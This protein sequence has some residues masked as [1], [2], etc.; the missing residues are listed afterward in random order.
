[1]GGGLLNLVAYGNK[2]I[3][4]N[5]NPSKTFFKTTY[6]KYTNFGLQKFRLDFDGPKVL[7]ENTRSYYEF[8]VPLYGDL[9]MDTY[10]VITMPHIWSPLY[11]PDIDPPCSNSPTDALW[12][13]CLRDASNN[14][15][16]QAFTSRVI[17]EGHYAQ[18]YEF[19]W[20]ENLGSQL[21]QSIRYTIGGQIVQEFSGQYLYNMVQR[22]FSTAKKNLFNE[23][24]GHTDQMN[25]PANFSTNSGNYPNYLGQALSCGPSI[26]GRQLYIPLNI[27]S[28]LSSKLSIPLVCLQKNQIK[29]NIECRPIRELFVVRDINQYISRQWDVSA[30]APGGLTYNTDIS[31]S[32]PPY[33]STMNIVDPKYQMYLFLTQL[34]EGGIA[35]LYPSLQSSGVVFDPAK[36]STWDADPHLIATYGFI[37]QEE[38]RQFVENPPSYLVKQVREHYIERKKHTLD[39][40][41]FRTSGL[42]SSWM[43][44]FQRDD[45]FLRNEWSNY[46]NWPYNYIPYPC[47]NMHDL[48]NNLEALSYPKPCAPK[49]SEA[50]NE[51]GANCFPYAPYSKFSDPSSCIPC[52]TGQYH[53]DNISRIMKIWSL[54][55]D[56]NIREK[57]LAASVLDNVEKYVRT[58][59]NGKDGLYCYNF[60][61]NTDP[62]QYQPNGAMN[63]S[64]VRHCEWQ[65]STFKPVL[66]TSAELLIVCDGSENI[67]GYNRVNWRQYKYNFNLHIMEERY[68]LIKF[69]NNVITLEYLYD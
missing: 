36:Q 7:R 15:T 60:C 21:I 66:D 42:V 62:F 4:I 41:R 46:T 20:I 17:S 8:T 32:A 14:G 55:L 69:G 43:W 22:D 54:I 59:G 28:T 23:M 40:I 68:N 6:A 58:A 57:D 26:R 51:L 31:Y 45:A 11:S 3:I 50:S 47:I 44:F 2:N 30:N 48:S 34:N 65:Y 18:P 61:L 37:G 16:L 63:L 53:T 25:D 1:M 33:I 12:I 49:W 39:N 56:G 64:S 35:N 19:K 29:I 38:T 13:E 27:W 52:I 24:T 5:G 67:I 10:F 9:L